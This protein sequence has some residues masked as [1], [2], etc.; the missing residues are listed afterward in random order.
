MPKLFDVEIVHPDEVKASNF[1]HQLTQSGFIDINKVY[2]E[3]YIN[4]DL[5]IALNHIK[6]GY[7]NY[8]IAGGW[9]EEKFKDIVLLI[10]RNRQMLTSPVFLRYGTRYDDG[11]LT[12][13]INLE[14]RKYEG[15]N[16]GKVKNEEEISKEEQ[17]LLDYLAKNGMGGK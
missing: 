16:K 9:S 3:N 17:E 10:A 13:E 7:K 5:G 14:K 6:Q 2:L 12:R 15:S 1:I 4:A 8:V 11:K